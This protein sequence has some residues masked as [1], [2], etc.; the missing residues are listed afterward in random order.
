MRLIDA[1]KLYLHLNDWACAEAPDGFDTG[2][3]TA[4]RE[5]VYKTILD[6][7]DAVEEQ[8]TAFDVDKVQRKIGDINVDTYLKLLEA[9]K[10]GGIND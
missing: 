8:P 4:S 3:A 9:I 7:M 2:E 10:R 1:D 5:V 6:C